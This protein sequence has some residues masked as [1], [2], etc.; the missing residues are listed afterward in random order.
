M[1]SEASPARVP[2]ATQAGDVRTRWAWTEPSVWT[3]RRLTALDEGVKGGVWFSISPLLANIYLD[4]LDHHLAAAGIEMV[5]YADDLVLRCRTEAEAQHALTVLR[6]WTHAAGLTLHPEQTRITDATQRG[7]FDCLGYHFERGRHWPRAKSVKKLKDT[8]RAKTARTRG[9]S[10]AVI[11]DDV[12][13]TL[14]GWF[15]YFQHRPR[16]ALRPLDEWVRRRLRSILR[17]RLRRSGSGRARRDHQRWPN[18]F[19]AMHGLYRL[20]DAHARACQSAPR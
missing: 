9:Q 18:A 5:R 3:D 14:R 11:I 15:V 2:L 10:L 12:N 20:T 7:G 6:A 4:P 17:T 19:F 8:L 1:N 16:H 13:R